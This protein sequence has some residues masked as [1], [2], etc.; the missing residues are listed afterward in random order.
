M[1]NFISS[2]WDEISGANAANQQKNALIDAGN[3]ASA[4]GLAYSNELLSF[5]SNLI[6]GLKSAGDASQSGYTEANSNLLNYLQ[7]ALGAS[8]TGTTKA[9]DAATTRANEQVAARTAAQTQGQN[10]INN[11]YET[12]KAAL[13]PYIQSSQDMLKSGNALLSM[14]GLGDG[15]YNPQLTDAY[16]IQEAEMT[17]GNNAAA[18]AKGMLNSPAALATASEQR[19]KLLASDT[20]N[21]IA[22]LLTMYNSGQSGAGNAT[23][24]QTSFINPTMQLAS[25]KAGTY[26]NLPDLSSLYQNAGNTQSNLYSNFG[27]QIANNAVNKGNAA[28]SNLNDIAQAQYAGNA[29]AANTKYGGFNN[30]NSLYA[31]AA[32]VKQP[33]TLDTLSSLMGIYKTGKGLF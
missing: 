6:P 23:S 1:A 14:Y 15:T 33:S 31:Q 7:Q 19:R 32:A 25:M 22:N 30:A 8:Q 17:R 16:R 27:T 29:T 2:F 5:L 21:T 18:A 9:V 13:A 26:D 12:A 3:S 4:T 24:L 20:Q 11:L 10:Q 28:A